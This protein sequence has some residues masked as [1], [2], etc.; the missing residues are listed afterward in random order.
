MEDGIKAFEI[1]RE[2][3]PDIQLVTFGDA[4]D[5]DVAQYAESYG[6]SYGDKLRKIYN[7]CDILLF[8]S[9]CEGFGLPPMEAM[10]CKCAVVSTDVGA[11]PDYTIPGETALVSPPHHPELLAENIIRLVKDEKLRRRISEAGYNYIRKFT[12]DEATDQLEQLFKKAIGE[13]I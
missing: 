7:S 4:P 1:A 12:W 3:H 13:K 8:P 2:K 9:H 10:A 6:R 11:I 5:L